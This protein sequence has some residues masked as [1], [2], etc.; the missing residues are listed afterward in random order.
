MTPISFL[1]VFIGGGLGASLRFLIG[2]LSGT[3]FLS[4]LIPNLIGC[5]LIGY[6]AHAF[7]SNEQIKLLFIVGFLGGFTTFSSYILFMSQQGFNIQSLIFFSV[8]NTLG[9]VLF[10][11]GY[12]T[13]VL[14]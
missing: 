3:Q 2:E 6:V 12:K 5:A 1:L 10:Y 9:F 4:V 11:L 13:S 8:H 7:G 14:L